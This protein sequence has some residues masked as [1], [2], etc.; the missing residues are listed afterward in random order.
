[1]GLCLFLPFILPIWKDLFRRPLPLCVLPLGYYFLTYV[2]GLA[3]TLVLPA[4]LG[5]PQN[6]QVQFSSSCAAFLPNKMTLFQWRKCGMWPHCP[7]TYLARKVRQTPALVYFALCVQ[8][9][10]MLMILLSHFRLITLLLPSPSV[11]LLS[12]ELQARVFKI[13]CMFFSLFSKV[14]ILSLTFLIEIK[15]WWEVVLSIAYFK[16]VRCSIY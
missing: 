9:E 7:V 12:A 10:R 15:E 3:I 14:F 5:C 2:V 11:S 8:M 6:L 13:F 4:I 16:E 1:M